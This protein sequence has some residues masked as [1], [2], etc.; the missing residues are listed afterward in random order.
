MEKTLLTIFLFLFVFSLIPIQTQAALVPCGNTPGDPCTFCH[1][2]ILINNIIRFVMFTLVPA[3]AVLMIIVGG[4][5][6]FFAGAKPDMLNQAKG[7]IT[8]V[9]IGLLIIFCAW[10]IVNT[11][12]QKIG[13]VQSPSLLQWYDIGCQ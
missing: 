12:I 5:M 2:F 7:I 10:V 11:V 4:V 9:V 8:S 1:F 3:I 6:F 13:I